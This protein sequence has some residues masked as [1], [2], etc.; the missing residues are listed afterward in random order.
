MDILTINPITGTA[1][2][3]SSSNPPKSMAVRRQK[4]ATLEADTVTLSYESEETD[5]D[6]EDDQAANG[7]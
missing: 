2:K 3:N 6:E 1:L 5:Y 4:K 7:Y